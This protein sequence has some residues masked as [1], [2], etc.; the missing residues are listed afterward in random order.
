MAKRVA[1]VTAE[2]FLSQLGPE[3]HR[4]MAARRE[5]QLARAA[6]EQAELSGLLG[7]I[8]ETGFVTD[9]VDALRR[10]GVVYK[11]AIHL[12]LDELFQPH[13]AGALEQIVRA[14]SV[15]YAGPDAGPALVRLFHLVPDEKENAS[16]KWAIGNALEIVA[17]G[18]LVDELLSVSLDRKFG[19]ARQMV[20]LALARFPSSE[21][22]DGLVSLLDDADVGGHAV[23]A[24]ARMR[25]PRTHPWLER[26]RDD[27]RTW[28]RKEVRNAFAKGK[29]RKP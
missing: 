22:I 29:R 17:D 3:Y 6:A 5:Q 16:L 27:P 15:P 14:M 9:S 12:L 20:V 4:K 18:S 19:R 23:T 10:S 25:D 21:V 24:L 13:S 1:G 28:V 7:R 11:K 2:A 8:R 26:F